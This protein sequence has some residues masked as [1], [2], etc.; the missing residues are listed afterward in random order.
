MTPSTPTSFDVAR[1]RNDFPILQTTANGHPLAYLDNGATTQKPRAVIDALVRFYETQNANIHRGVYGLSQTATLLYEQARE[2]IRAFI[3]AR[4]TAEVIFT[5]GATEG[6]NLVASSWGRANLTPGDVVIV[7]HLEHHSD[8]VPWQMACAAAGAELRVI[9]ID[10]AGE[11]V[12]AEFDRLL[13]DA[14]GRVRLVAVNHVSNSLGTVNPVKDVITRARGAGAV[15]LIDGAQWVAHGPTDVQ[16]LDADFYVCSG[17]KMMGPTGVGVLYGKRALLEAMPP[18]QGGGDMIESVRFDKTTYAG[19]PNKFEA[20][21]PD[22]AGVVGLGAAVDYLTALDLRVTAAYEQNLLVYGTRRLQE[23]PGLR[24]LGT[25]PPERKAAVLSFVMDGPPLRGPISTLDIG[26]ALDRLGVCVRTG[27]H[28]CQPVMERY[29]VAATARASFAFYNTREEIDRLVDGL[30]AIATAH[31]HAPAQAVPTQSPAKPAAAASAIEFPKATAKG[32][33]AA[34]EALADEF[35]LMEE[36]GG[37]DAKSEYVMDLAKALP[38]TF[39]VLKQVTDRVP[40]CMS[41]VY[42]VARERPA[43]ESGGQAGLFEFVADADAEIVRGLIAVLERLY[44]GQ[45]AAD[46]LAFDVE[47]F[48]ERIGL[49][50]FITS[51]R[52][53]GL[54]GMVT[55]IRAAAKEIAAAK[56]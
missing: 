9:P 43:G 53:N 41:Q 4:E 14:A 45:R 27:H 21:T 20:G 35:A 48:F 31:L 18:Y 10:D 33:K 13:D 52:R 40:G 22:I 44:S 36:A 5:R 54:A 38:R 51:Q 2:K 24:V 37:R 16:A 19:L 8:I 25:A 23:V 55:K 56:V 29:G 6:I 17:H 7:S 50:S 49:E 46:V 30:K 47:Q 11:L 26:V 32:I 34:A 3:N 42:L 39:D 12:M 1:V 28:C 15:V